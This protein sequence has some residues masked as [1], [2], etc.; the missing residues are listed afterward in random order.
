MMPTTTSAPGPPVYDP[1]TLGDNLEMPSFVFTVTVDNTNGGQLSEN[2][3]T[4]GYVQEPTSMYKLATF[5][6][7]GVT[8]GTRSYLVGGRTYVEDQLRSWYLYEAGSP[9]APQPANDPNIRSSILGG[10][11]TAQFVG[12]EDYAGLPANHFMFNETNLASYASYTPEKPSPTVEGDFYLA[13]V[14]NYVLFAHSK[15]TSPG[16]V[17]EVTEAMTSV[18]QVANIE[19]PADLAPMGQALD[20]GV[21]LTPLL[22]PGS[23]LSTMV[24]YS[25]G[26]GV[27]YYRYIAPLQSNEELVDFYRTFPA[28]AGWSVAHVGHIALHLEQVNCETKVDC[29]L[30]RNGGEQIVI[31]LAGTII[32]EYDHQHVFSPA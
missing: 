7:D 14:G 30:L 25:N 10:V 17:Y 1:Q 20:I 32:V 23:S 2:I 31:S 15:E 24:R 28:T 3:T 18:G 26:I 21:G 29:V 6:Y 8:D 13:Q 22:P 12:Q 11:V 4:I 19:L 9:V 27:D 16:R 5:S